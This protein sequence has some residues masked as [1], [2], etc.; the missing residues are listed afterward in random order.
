MTSPIENNTKPLTS[1]SFTLHLVI[2]HFHLLIFSL[3][4][5]LLLSS[6]ALHFHLVFFTYI[7]YS[8]VISLIFRSCPSCL[9]HIFHLLFFSKTKA[10]PLLRND[11]FC[12]S[13]RLRD[14]QRDD[15]V[16]WQ[17]WEPPS[18]IQ[19]RDRPSCCKVYYLEYSETGH[20]STQRALTALFQNPTFQ[21]LGIVSP[22][23]QFD[24]FFNIRHH[25]RGSI[26]T[27]ENNRG[28]TNEN[29]EELDSGQSQGHAI[30]TQFRRWTTVGSLDRLMSTAR[31]HSK[32]LPL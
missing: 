12:R 5:L 1:Y 22:I 10:T 6:H 15:S 20:A 18:Q 31:I 27:L 4:F 2:L 14:F 8:L 16:P 24:I 11:T 29:D 30:E 9:V 3:V 28:D 17:S 25:L 26:H 13:T 7:S 19:F 21:S 23:Y 32:A